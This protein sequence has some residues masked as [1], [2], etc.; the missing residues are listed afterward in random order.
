MFGDLNGLMQQTFVFMLW[1]SVCYI[2]RSMQRINEAHFRSRQWPFLSPYLCIA[3][4]MFPRLRHYL[5]DTLISRGILCM[6]MTAYR[7]LDCLCVRERETG[8][9]DYLRFAPKQFS[10][11]N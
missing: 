1:Y 4:V 5:R 2:R 9:D 3:N 6:V 7:F 10:P 8:C 11:A